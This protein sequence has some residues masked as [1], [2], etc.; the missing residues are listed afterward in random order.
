MIGSE[1]GGVDHPAIFGRKWRSLHRLKAKQDG[2]VLT[3]VLT[4]MVNE[5]LDRRM[6]GRDALSAIFIPDKTRLIVPYSDRRM[7]RRND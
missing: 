6:D 5:L 2:E 3:R 4:K 1:G 7:N